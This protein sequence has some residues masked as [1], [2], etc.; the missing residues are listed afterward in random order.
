MLNNGVEE[1]DLVMTFYIDGFDWVVFAITGI[2]MKCFSSGETGYL[3][4]A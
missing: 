4:C 3:V 2:G 1:L